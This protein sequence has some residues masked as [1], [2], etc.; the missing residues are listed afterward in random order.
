MLLSFLDRLEDR[1]TDDS[2]TNDF[3]D[4]DARRFKIP[5]TVVGWIHLD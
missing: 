1:V 5:L 3:D 2:L 4:N